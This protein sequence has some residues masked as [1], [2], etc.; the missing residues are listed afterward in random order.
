MNQ[1]Q[2]LPGQILNISIC[3]LVFS[4]LFNRFL[5]LFFIVN[6]LL[7]ILLVLRHTVHSSVYS[8][9][10]KT[11]NTPHNTSTIN[12]MTF[13]LPLCFDLRFLT[14]RLLAVHHAP[15]VFVVTFYL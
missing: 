12:V 3:L 10:V 6:L 5:V 4:L 2:L 13:I 8:A 15:P 7:Q 9:N 1:S 14:D 11:P